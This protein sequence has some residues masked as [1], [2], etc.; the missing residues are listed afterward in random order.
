MWLL[1]VTFV[2]LPW[3]VLLYFFVRYEV[4]QWRID[5]LSVRGFEV[6]SRCQD[7]GKK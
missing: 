1:A 4:R 5:R 2:S 6:E 7:D 3:L